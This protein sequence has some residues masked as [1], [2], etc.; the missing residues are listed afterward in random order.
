[1]TLNNLPMKGRIEETL[2]KDHQIFLYLPPSWT[3]EN[4]KH[5][6]AILVQDGDQAVKFL[7]SIVEELETL[8]S[9][10]KGQELMI[11]MVLPVNRLSEYTPWPARAMDSRFPDFEGKGNAYL[12]YLEKELLPWLEE[13]YKAELSNISLLGYSLGGLINIY[14]LTIQNCWN[15]VAGICSSFWYDGWISYLENIKTVSKKGCIYLHYGVSEGKGKSGPMEN[16]PLFARKT[17]QLLKEIFHCDVTITSDPGGHHS[18]VKQRYLNGIL[19]L[20]KQI[21]ATCE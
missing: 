9:Y 13:S 4:S 1:M 21:S 12:F 6:P 11:A 19:W 16:A 10:G 2:Y 15:H 14:A 8:W 5:Y 18:R 3:M 20:H 17:S 7:P